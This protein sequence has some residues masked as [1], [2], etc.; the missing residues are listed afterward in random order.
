MFEC[1]SHASFFFFLKGTG[2]GLFQTFGCPICSILFSY[3]IAR[4]NNKGLQALGSGGK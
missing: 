2:D 4:V 1:G 3:L